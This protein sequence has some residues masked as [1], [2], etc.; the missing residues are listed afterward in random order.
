MIAVCMY[1]ICALSLW[2]WGRHRVRGVVPTIYSCDSR[3]KIRLRR[4]ADSEVK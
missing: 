3:D 2:F 1:V 4:E